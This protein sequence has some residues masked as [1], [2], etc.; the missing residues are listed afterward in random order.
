MARM[1]KNTTQIKELG[2]KIQQDNIPKMIQIDKLIEHE[3]NEYL[4]GENDEDTIKNLAEGIKK[5]GFNGAILVWDMKNGR[6]RNGQDGRR[7]P[8]GKIFSLM[9]HITGY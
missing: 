7:Y 9:M 8:K 3:D 4:F 2:T 1:L 6:R 5:D